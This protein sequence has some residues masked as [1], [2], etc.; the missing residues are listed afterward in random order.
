MF[1]YISAGE[2]LANGGSDERLRTLLD[3]EGVPPLGYNGKNSATSKVF[4]RRFS[5]GTSSCCITKYLQQAHVV[6]DV[7][8]R[9]LP[10]RTGCRKAC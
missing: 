2:R 10:S 9:L 5:C 1:E 3:D 7:D 4:C 8:H 6:N